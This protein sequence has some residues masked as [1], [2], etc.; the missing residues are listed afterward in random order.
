MYSFSKRIEEL[1]EKQRYSERK[2]AKL[3]GL[4]SSGYRSALKV[5]DW[6]VSTVEKI[7]NVFKCN[8]LD[9]LYEC[10]TEFEKNIKI[11]TKYVLPENIITKVSE[12]DVKYKINGLNDKEKIL[13]L[14]A[15][16]NELRGQVEYFRHLYEKLNK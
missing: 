4:S 9:F 11:D 5:D 7:C 16:I 6:R 3:I 13:I 8:F 2:F 14:E 10:S 12:S 1:R 15:T